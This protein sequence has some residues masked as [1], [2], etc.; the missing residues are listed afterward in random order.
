MATVSVRYIVQD[1]DAALAFYCRHLGF[2]EQMHP[3]PSFAMLTRGDLRL[4]LSAPS[5]GPR[6]RRA[7]PQVGVPDVLVETHRGGDEGAAAFAVEFAA[8][9][10][11]GQVSTEPLAVAPRAT[12]GRFP[13]RGADADDT[14]P[15]SC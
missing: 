5:G 7:R 3:A 1:V 14:P 11:T 2:A 6:A 15:R 4:L 9:S 8:A 12:R 10:R 13:W